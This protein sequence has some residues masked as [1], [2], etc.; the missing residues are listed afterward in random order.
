MERPGD[1]VRVLRQ[2]ATDLLNQAHMIW[3]GESA[4]L[5]SSPQVKDS[6]RIRFERRELS[7][8]YKPPVKNI[9]RMERSSILQGKGIYRADVKQ[10]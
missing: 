3:N 10:Y 6:A 2:I 9:V 8:P 5:A 7:T 1:L 4:H